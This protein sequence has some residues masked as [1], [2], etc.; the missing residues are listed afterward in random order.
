[1]KNIK[2]LRN[3]L[4]ETMKALK[5]GHLDVDKAKTIS[6]LGQVIVNTAKVE[7]DFI[8]AAKIKDAT[9]FISDAII[10]PIEDQKQELG[11]PKAEYSN[12]GHQKALD[13][14]AK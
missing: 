4:G 11:R 5:D 6:D 9:D 1:M 8:K 3:F 2:E 10:K 7:V 12:Q 14:Y 13:K